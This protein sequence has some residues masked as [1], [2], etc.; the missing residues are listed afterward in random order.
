MSLF[1]EQS[2][3]SADVAR[4]IT[5]VLA[6]GYKVSFGEA[7]RTAEQQAIYVKTGRSKTLKS[8]HLERLAVDLNFKSKTGKMLCSVEDHAEIGRYWESLSIKNRWGGNFD[9]DWSKSDNFKDAPHFE[10][11]V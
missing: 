7:W 9:K 6:Q 3:F 1:D 4:L 11:V 10:R 2:A 5:W 8:K